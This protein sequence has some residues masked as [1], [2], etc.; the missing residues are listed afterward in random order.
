MWH[1][2]PVNQDVPLQEP[3]LTA[4]LASELRAVVSK[5]KRRF[6]EHGGRADLTPSQASVIM[7]LEKEGSATVAALA[8]AEGIRHQSM[9]AAVGSLLEADLVRGTPDPGDGRQM[10]ISL[11]PRCLK[12]LRQGRAARQDWLTSTIAQRLSLREQ[13]KL[14]TALDLLTRIVED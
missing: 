12:W 8:R 5:L 14:R 3:D 6:R 9:S 7:R 4:A 11:T 2:G 13:E 10:L 1:T